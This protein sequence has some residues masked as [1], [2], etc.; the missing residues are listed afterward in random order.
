MP[1][2]ASIRIIRLVGDQ[3]VSAQRRDRPV[4]PGPSSLERISFY[5]KRDARK[6]FLRHI[7][8]FR[9]GLPRERFK[10]S[11]Y[12]CIYNDWDILG[13][14]LDSIADHVDELIVVDGAYEWMVPFLAATGCDPCR[15]DQRVYDAVIASGI[16]FRRINRTWKNE[17]EKRVAGYGACSHRFVLR[18]DADEVLFFNEKNLEAFLASGCAV[19]EMDMPT[20]I[21]PGWIVRTTRLRDFYR[22]YPSQRCLFDSQKISAEGH[23]KYL[24]LVIPADTLPKAKERTF[25]VFE[26]PIAFCAHL[27]SWRT[28]DTAVNRGVFYVMNWMR[29]HGAPWL[30][31]L[32]GR[33]MERFEEFFESIPA[34]TFREVLKRGAVAQGTISL[35]PRETLAKSP[36]SGQQEKSLE[37]HYRAFLRALAVQTMKATEEAQT[38]ILGEPVFLDLSTETARSS[39]AEDGLVR[40]VTSLPLASVRITL[41]ALATSPP[42]SAAQPIPATVE[43]REV[44]FA[45]PGPK[46]ECLRQVIELVGWAGGGEV[47]CTFRIVP[48]RAAISGRED[49]ERQEREALG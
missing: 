30:P 15:S 45:L 48:R 49:G 37:E 39:L 2:P 20:Y 10:V 5:L 1:R 32:N 28:V 35:G 42:L 6:I 26:R 7:P 17:V 11:A 31:K 36:L 13:A 38:M 8:L 25:S 33:P 34:P 23:L 3:R 29:K 12:L 19:A 27:T 46:P 47:L 43:G 40:I 14:A 16:P 18:V 24:W 41:H 22:K 21:A 9:K 4:R 44:R